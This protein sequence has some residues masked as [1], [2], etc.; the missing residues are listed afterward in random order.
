MS[1]EQAKVTDFAIARTALLAKRMPMELT[2]P[3]PVMTVARRNEII[4]E[5]R[6]QRRAQ[7]QA[8][9]DR[10]LMGTEMDREA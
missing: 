7:E 10:L 8:N 6:E 9:Y 5:W 3:E 4:R 2:E 1:H